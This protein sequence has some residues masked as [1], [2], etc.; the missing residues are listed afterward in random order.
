[1]SVDDGEVDALGFVPLELRFQ[2]RLGVGALGE[3]HEAGGV[4]IDPVHDER[5][6]LAVRPKVIDER[7][8]DRRLIPAKRERARSAVQP[9]C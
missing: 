3:D 1:M 7:I 5:P 4:A 2:A 6:A 9:A 8:F